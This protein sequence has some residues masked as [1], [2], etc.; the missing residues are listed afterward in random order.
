MAREWESEEELVGCGPGDPGGPEGWAS[1][2]GLRGW[3]SASA[4]YLK[5]AVEVDEP[6]GPDSK[7]QL[8]PLSI[9]VAWAIAS[10]RLDGDRLV[11]QSGSCPGPRGAIVFV[12]ARDPSET[13]AGWSG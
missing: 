13:A 12:G 2:V 4:R 6:D 11:W 7:I 10:S 1:S 9:Q 5:L 8:E 3:R